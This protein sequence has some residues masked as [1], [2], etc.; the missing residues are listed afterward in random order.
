MG[1]E[2]AAACMRRGMELARVALSSKDGSTNV[3]ATSVELVGPASA[4]ERARELVDECAARG[5]T[6]VAVDYTVPDACLGNAQLYAR[7]GIP[8]VM[9]TTGG[10]VAAMERA[11][12]SAGGEEGEEGNNNNNKKT[13][14]A[15]IAPNMAKQI[16]AL[17]AAIANAAREFPGAFQGYDLQVVE[18]HQA[19][20]KDTSGTAKAVVA[21]LLGLVDEKTPDDDDTKRAIDAIERVRDEPTQLDGAGGR[22]QRVP[23]DN[24]KGHAYHTYSLTSP[25]ADV[26]FEL[27][28]NVNGRRVYAEGTADAVL[29]LARR[30]DDQTTTNAAENPRTQR[31]FNM[32]DVLKSGELAS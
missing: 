10:D 22:L 8:F 14:K 17:Q 23:K 19:T 1:H 2:V 7:H 27:R 20:K 6:L 18:S 24:L 3:E 31:I 5:K 28:H 21:S 15:V 26:R 13:C 16:V 11:V 30:L 12:L 32:I 4:E 25:L 9:G 29:F